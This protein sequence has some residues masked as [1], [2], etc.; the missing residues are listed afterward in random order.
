M[1][2][3]SKEGDIIAV[4]DANYFVYTQGG[5]SRIGSFFGS[6]LESS[7]NEDRNHLSSN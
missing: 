4:S 7:T 3:R 5:N 6:H 2:L 1:N